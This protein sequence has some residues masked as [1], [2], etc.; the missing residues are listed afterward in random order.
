M[1]RLRAHA[2]AVFLA[3][4]LACSI[5]EAQSA[6]PTCTLRLRVEL[7]PDVPNPSDPGFVS[8]LLGNNTDFRLTL[9]RVIDDSTIDLQLFGPGI[10]DRCREVVDSI[11]QDSRVLSIDVRDG[12]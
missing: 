10:I 7:T 8:S 2:C 9:M 5:N 1:K 11:G 12:G 4:A 6:P 3:G